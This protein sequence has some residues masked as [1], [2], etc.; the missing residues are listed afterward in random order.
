MLSSV[1]GL[2]TVSNIK[3]TYSDI[4]SMLFEAFSCNMFP[5]Q[6]LLVLLETAVLY[7]WREYNV[8]HTS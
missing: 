4:L 1:S 5:S 3:S 2:K 8:Q 7:K 6:T